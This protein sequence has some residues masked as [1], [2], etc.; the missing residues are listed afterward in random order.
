MVWKHPG[1]T[2]RLF[3]MQNKTYFNNWCWLLRNRRREDLKCLHSDFVLKS[4]AS[5]TKMLVIGPPCSSSTR[6]ACPQQDMAAHLRKPWAPPSL[7][8]PLTLTFLALYF[9][10]TI[11]YENEQSEDSH[12]TWAHCIWRA[13]EHCSRWGVTS[14]RHRRVQ[15]L[16]FL[17]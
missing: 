11:A 4:Q 14:L 8:E 17:Q 15:Q 1:Y 5:P 12:T 9:T 13:N 3:R 2:P 6:M 16:K 10:Q 7:C